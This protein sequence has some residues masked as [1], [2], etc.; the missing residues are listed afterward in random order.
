MTLKIGQ[1]EPS[2]PVVLAPM[3][4]VTNAPFREM[5]RRFAPGLIYVNEMVMAT[6]VVHGNDKTDRMISFGPGEHPRSLQLYGSD[7]EIMGKA[8]AKLCD[9]GRVDH[10]DL[11]FGCPAAKVTRRGGGAA[12]PARPEL[13]RAI[14][15]AA[16]GNAS[17]YGVPVTAKFRMGLFDDW[18]THVRTGE[19]CAEEG[20]AAIALHARTVQQHYSGEAQ[21]EAIAELKGAVGEIPVLGNGDIWEAKDAV[22]MI[23]ETGCDGVVIGRGCLGRPWLFGDLVDALSGRPVRPSRSLGEVMAVMLDHARLLAGHLGENH[24][25]RDFRKHTGWYM[26]GYPVG[27]E[28]R[29]R[30][31]MIKSL[32]ELE[33]LLADLDPKAEI[34]EDGERIKRG[35]T[36]G[37]VKVSLPEGWLDGH[38]REQLLGDVDV[39][40]DA[41]VAAVS[42]G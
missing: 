5:C 16:V 1:F 37:P 40:D 38:R 42:G 9:A 34:V 25:M 21:W 29:R 27:P 3:A 4:G 24:A 14:L 15:R 32:M 36:N 35:H 17:P 28:A 31:S 39:P 12:V 41:D 20:V 23:A 11:N 30:F 22:R 13:L 26:S 8:V 7:P 18:L 2:A 19:V 10:I 33:D 6:P